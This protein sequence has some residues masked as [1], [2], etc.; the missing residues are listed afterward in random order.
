MG[1]GVISHT[2]SPEIRVGDWVRKE[3]VFEVIS[4]HD[5]ISLSFQKS[6]SAEGVI[7][8]DDFRVTPYNSASQAFVY[9]SETYNV[10]AILDQNNFAALYQYDEQG[11]LVISK[12]ETLEGIKSI[13]SNRSNIKQ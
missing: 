4:G 5:N 8:I 3:Y 10:K 11:N 7:Y 12:K 2:A 9:D 6:N 13:S 1:A